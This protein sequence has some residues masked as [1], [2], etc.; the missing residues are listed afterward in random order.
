MQFYTIV[1]TEIFKQEY[2]TKLAKNIIISLFCHPQMVKQMLMQHCFIHPLVRNREDKDKILQECLKFVDS[3]DG[4]V[5]NAS[6]ADLN[7]DKMEQMIA[8]LSWPYIEKKWCAS[9]N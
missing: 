1:D 8:D 7:V 3:M 6:I 5:L 9:R 4:V 2:E